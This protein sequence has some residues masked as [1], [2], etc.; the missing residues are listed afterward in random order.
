[1]QSLQAKASEW[2]GVNQDDAFA[3]DDDNLFQ[4]LG[5][6]T[7]INLST[8]FYTRLFIYFWVE[9]TVFYFTSFAMEQTVEIF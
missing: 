8:N 3:I 4:K 9:D 7:F 6:Q 5:L 2:S 1:M